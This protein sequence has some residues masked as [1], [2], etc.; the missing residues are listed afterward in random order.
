M[1]RQQTAQPQQLQ[2]G[3][4]FDYPGVQGGS[5]QWVEQDETSSNIVTTL[6]QANQQTVQGIQAFRQTD[7]AIDWQM[8]CSISQTYTA[9]TSTFVASAYAPMN[10]LGPVILKIQN[11]YSSVDV[12]SGIDLYIFNLI[13][14]FA[15]GELQSGVNAGANPAGF[16]LGGSAQ[17]YQAAALAQANNIN[18]AQWTS[19]VA[20]Y[21]LYLRIP[22][23]QWFDEYY[24]LALTGE[25]VTPP[26]AAL[27]SPQ[28]MAGTTRN[29][30]PKVTYNQGQ[31]S[32]TD[33]APVQWSSGTGT[34]TGTAT[35]R[36]RRRAIYAG[37]AAV[38]PPIYAWQYTWKTN[39]VGVNGL[40]KVSITFPT[41][42][43]QIL[44][45]YV[46]FFDPAA[47]AGVGAPIANTTWTLIRLEYG[48]GLTW[49]DAGNDGN[50]LPAEIIQRRWLASHPSLLPAGVVALD[51]AIDERQ[52]MSNKR[53]LNTL[54]TGGILWRFQ[55]ASP[56][57][58]SAYAVLGTESL[59]YVS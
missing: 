42:T 23:S 55:A 21:Q 35:T 40:S 26:H 44:S 3:Q 41:D 9:G 5:T 58:A 37:D 4:L 14:P 46:R 32:T 33:L 12:E 43:G 15:S 16:P 20:S 10:V 25:A 18:S 38:L 11:Q 49:F 2:P 17:G 27:V 34:F 47:S 31:G 45:T 50:I 57:S 7:V 28:Y 13:R 39:R 54:T 48:S 52:Q 24:D 6:A 8:L 51:L 1:A 53:C 30:T 59:V 22:C 56:L 29:I 36:F 19:A